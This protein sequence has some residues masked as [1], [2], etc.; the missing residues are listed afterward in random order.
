MILGVIF[1]TSWPY[2]LGP[3]LTLWEETFAV[4]DAALMWE[5]GQTPALFSAQ[6]PA[7]ESTA[8]RPTTGS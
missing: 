3:L 4:T 7:A 8:K 2:S 6:V 5:D 1:L